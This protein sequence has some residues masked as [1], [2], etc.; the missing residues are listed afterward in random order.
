MI[1]CRILLLTITLVLLVFSGA[2]QAEESWVVDGKSGAKI[3]WANEYGKL[4]SATWSGPVVDGKA[5][6]TGSLQV[7]IR[8]IDGKKYT[9]RIEGSMLGGKLHGKVT[10]KWSNGDTFDGS[11]VDGK[12]EGKGTYFYA[13]RGG[14]IYEGEFRNDRPEGFGIYKTSNGKVIYEG[15][16]V[17]GTPETR[18][19]LDKVLG[20]AWGV[21]QDVVKKAMLERPKTSLI[22]TVQRENQVVEQQYWGPFNGREQWI[23]FRF[24]EG[25]MYMALM[26]QTLPEDKLEQV[27]ETFEQ[28]RKGLAERYGPADSETGKYL[29]SSNHWYWGGDRPRTVYLSIVR[30]GQ[31]KPV[32][33]VVRLIYLDVLTYAKAEVKD[34]EAGSE[35]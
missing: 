3:G 15:Q 27:M 4:L 1:R 13:E 34:S 20:L 32:T 26:G 21:S 10:Q 28:A 23:L 7:T 25:K 2:A 14:R 33:F 29:D 8:F 22:N 11:Y 9:G 30:D 5:E 6:G 24:F 16:W 31:T 17:N 18:P 19:P 35:Y 12:I